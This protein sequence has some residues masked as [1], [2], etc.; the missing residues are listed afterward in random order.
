MMD[1]RG[2]EIRYSEINP[3]EGPIHMKAGNKIIID[4]NWPNKRSNDRYLYTNFP[5]LPRLVKL[6]DTFFVDDG[7]CVL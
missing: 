6:R 4:V 3:Q 7:K 1:L 5:E 2:R